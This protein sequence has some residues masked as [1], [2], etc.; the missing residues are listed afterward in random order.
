M[1][2]I[3][4]NGVVFLIITCLWNKV[5]KKAVEEQN[6]QI[7][8]L[9]TRL[10]NYEMLHYNKKTFVEM[11]SH[12]TLN[13]IYDMGLIDVLCKVFPKLDICIYDNKL[14]RVYLPKKSSSLCGNET[15][16]TFNKLYN[17]KKG[18]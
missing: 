2:V 18:K 17:C 4:G 3:I 14:N 8:N 13:E 10:T 7:N 11:F 9:K 16:N 12:Y 1:E 15:V 6:V 5:S